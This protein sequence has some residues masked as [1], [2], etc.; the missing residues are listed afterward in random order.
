MIVYWDKRKQQQVYPLGPA[1]NNIIRVNSTRCNINWSYGM[2]TKDLIEFEVIDEKIEPCPEMMGKKVL[3]LNND[4]TGGL[5]GTIRFWNPKNHNCIGV[6]FKEYIGGHSLASQKDF[7]HRIYGGKCKDGY[8]WY[9][10]SEKLC[11]I[12]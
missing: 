3:S 6:E 11:Y 9:I 1:E 7:H 5:I 4:N 12:E 8:G 2:F 10:T